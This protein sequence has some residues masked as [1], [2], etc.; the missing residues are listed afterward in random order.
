MLTVSPANEGSVSTWMT[1]WISDCPVSTSGFGSTLTVIWGEAPPE[2]PPEAP[3]AP[4]AVWHFFVLGCLTHL[5]VALVALADAT[6]DAPT[7]DMP[8][9]VMATTTVAV[10]RRRGRDRV[11]ISSLFAVRST[12]AGRLGWAVCGR[13]DGGCGRVHREFGD[14]GGVGTG[15]HVGDDLGGPRGAGLAHEDEDGVAV[16]VEIGRGV[17]DQVDAHAGDV[18]AGR[19]DPDAVLVAGDPGPGQ[20]AAG[21]ELGRTDL[22]QLLGVDG[23][24]L[25]VED[26]VD[27]GVTARRGVARLHLLG[28][29][30]GLG[31]AGHAFGG[32][33]GREGHQGGEGGEERGDL[34]VGL[35]HGRPRGAVIPF[36]DDGGV[37]VIVEDG[38]D[39]VVE[40]SGREEVGGGGGDGA[41]GD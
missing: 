16:V 28:H 11:V 36:E 7:T 23:V 32:D 26:G 13:S 8:M 25:H 29:T 21:F 4:P 34:E 31:E 22:H 37:A 1:A 38:T 40:P 24:R 2:P 35:D 19:A 15:F 3:V 18:V 41:E 14:V 33:R 6:A 10:I 12:V 9:T 39:P 20:D 27:V 30:G 5:G 17:L